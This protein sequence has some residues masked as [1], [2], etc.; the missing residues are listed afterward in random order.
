MN[1][2]IIEKHSELEEVINNCE[3]CYVSMVDKDGKPYVLP[4][5]FAYEDNKIYLHSGNFGK[6]LDILKVNPDVCIAFSLGHQLFHHHE[7]VAC[8]YSMT[9]KS[10]VASGRV[11]F[12][13]DILKK[14]DIMNKVMMKYTGKTF[15]YS[16]PAITNVSCFVINIIE[17]SGR[18]RGM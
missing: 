14:T 18:N 16:K 13:E 1:T 4:F 3:V 10:V 2:K 17:I 11:E 8:S 9:Y 5:N 7:T 6:K 15:E 12:E